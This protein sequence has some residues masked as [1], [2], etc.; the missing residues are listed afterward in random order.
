MINRAGCGA[1]AAQAVVNP[2]MIKRLL[3]T[4]GYVLA[5]RFFKRLAQP[6]L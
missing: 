5:L 2:S 3:K 1:S 6:L 4:I